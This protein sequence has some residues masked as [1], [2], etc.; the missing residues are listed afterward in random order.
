MPQQIDAPF[1]RHFLECFYAAVNAH[2]ADAGTALCCDDVVWADPG[3]PETLRGRDAVL[4]FRRDILFPPFRRA[5]HARRGPSDRWRAESWQLRRP[6]QRMAAAYCRPR[7]TKTLTDRS[8]DRNVRPAK[9]AI[10]RRSAPPTQGA[11]A[12]R[13][14]CARGIRRRMETTLTPCRFLSFNSLFRLRWWSGSRPHPSRIRRHGS[15]RP[16]DR[17]SRQFRR[18]RRAAP[19][20]PCTAS[21]NVRRSDFRRVDSHEH[22]RTLS[23]PWQHRRGRASADVSMN[24]ALIWIMVDVCQRTVGW[25][26]AGRG[27]W[28]E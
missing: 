16:G 27:H 4:R 19:A 26:S 13:R 22:R 15:E 24:A 12:F 9:Q 1:A 20:H 23:G 7:G 2:D 28:N 6:H 11:S 25:R 5:E 10:E 17:R 14:R 18:V 3:A 8:P 21:G